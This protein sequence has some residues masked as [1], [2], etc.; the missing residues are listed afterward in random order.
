MSG[1]TAYKCKNCGHVMY[2]RHFRCLQCA[3]REFEEIEPGNTG[4]LV[5]FTDV[6]N[7]PWG[8]DERVRTIGVVEFDDGVKAMGR[9]NV[10]KPKLGMRLEARWAPVRVI[11]GEEVYGLTFERR[12]R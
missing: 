1:I 5:T 2:P 11:R 9:L 3:G 8:I 4:R 7:L 12:T 6:H 10:E